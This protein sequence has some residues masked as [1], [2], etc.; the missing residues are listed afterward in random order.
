MFN[1]QSV[2]KIMYYKR[3]LQGCRKENLSMKDNLTK[4]KTLCDQLASVGHKIS[5][6]EQV[7]CILGG[8]DNKYE[9]A[10]A[11]ISSK[12]VTPSI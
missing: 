8:L 6:T 5:N 11:V 2:A 4:I 7:L 12:E 10:V 9:S 1:T 3:Q